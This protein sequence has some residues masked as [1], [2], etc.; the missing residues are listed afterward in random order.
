MGR[1][2]ATKDSAGT[3]DRARKVQRDKI[4][5]RS[6]T[7]TASTRT[8]QMKGGEREGDWDFPAVAYRMFGSVSFATAIT[9]G[10]PAV[11]YRLVSFAISSVRYSFVF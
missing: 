10:Y 9:V 11:A 8:R 3:C 7:W 5:W 2:G 1:R 4:L 6:R